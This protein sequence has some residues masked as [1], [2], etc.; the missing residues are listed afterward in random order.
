MDMIHE[1]SIM[2]ISAIQDKFRLQSQFMFMISNLFDPRYAF[3]FYA[4]LLFSLDRYTGRKLMWVSVVAEWSNQVLKWILMGERPYWWVHE[5]DVYTNRTETFEQPEIRQFFMTCETGPGSPSG[6]AMVTAAVFY[7]LVESLLRQ[8]G[9]Q[10]KSSMVNRFCWALYTLILCTVSLSR[11][12]LAAHFPHQC[13]LGS[14]I[15]VAVAMLVS[16]ADT[17][18]F[19]RKHYILGS[20][21][22]FASAMTTYFVIKSLGV[23]PMWTLTRATK[24]CAKAEYVHID[25]TPFFSVMRYCGFFL[26]M[27][28]GLFSN[29]YASAQKVQFTTGMK[30]LSALMA[31]GF[32]KASEFVPLPRSHLYLTYFSAFVIS[33]ILPYLFIAVV[34]YIV[35]KLNVSKAKAKSS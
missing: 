31:V 5:T 27:G 34:P 33:A 11:V 32:A 3:L 23:D 12:Y 35:S 30:I 8:H 18:S 21:A 22:M 7:I 6:H 25:T 1:T 26:G 28:F 17:D 15:G 14:V 9:T 10:T 4:P 24:W 29:L 13:L 16:N 19:Q 20:A 2:A